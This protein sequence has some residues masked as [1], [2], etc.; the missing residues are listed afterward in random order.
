MGTAADDAGTVQQGAEPEA[1]GGVSWCTDEGENK[2][3]ARKREG[4]TKQKAEKVK[5]RHHDRS[6]TEV[7]PLFVVLVRDV[8]HDVLNAAIQDRAKSIQNQGFDHHV[9]PQAVKLGIVD[10]IVF[11]ECVLADA[12]LFEGFPQALVPYH[13]TTTS[14]LYF[15]RRGPIIILCVCAQYRRMIRR[16]K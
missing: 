11:D 13:S 1:D 4:E 15:K 6:K 10:S 2:G 12:I 9:V 7:M 8:F 5:Q 14:P 3:K 16:K